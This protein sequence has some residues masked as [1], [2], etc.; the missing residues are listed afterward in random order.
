MHLENGDEAVIIE[1]TAEEVTEQA[2]IVRVVEHY[3]EKYAWDMVPE[4]LPGPFWRVWS[5][6]AFGWVSDGSG[7]DGGAAF[8]G[9]AT[10]WRFDRS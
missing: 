9:T 7:L 4:S 1:G 3:N 8:H 10:R 6:I 5:R 2:T